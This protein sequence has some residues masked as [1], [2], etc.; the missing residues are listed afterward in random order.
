M[1][2]LRGREGKGFTIRAARISIMKA[3]WEFLTGGSF[4]CN[5]TPKPKFYIFW[6]CDFKLNCRERERETESNPGDVDEVAEIVDD[7]GDVGLHSLKQRLLLLSCRHSSSRGGPAR[8]ASQSSSPWRCTSALI[9]PCSECSSKLLIWVVVQDGSEFF[10]SQESSII[11]L[12]KFGGF[13]G[14]IRG[15]TMSF[16]DRK[17]VFVSNSNVCCKSTLLHQNKKKK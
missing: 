12:S 1:S 9:H 11:L 2:K 15:E 4:T 6:N 13:V 17:H 3:S 16:W 14:R 5:Y 10:T 8:R 7:A